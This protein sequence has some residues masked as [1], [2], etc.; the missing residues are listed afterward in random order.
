MNRDGVGGLDTAEGEQRTD[1]E[2]LLSVRWRSTSESPVAPFARFVSS[3]SSYIVGAVGDAAAVDDATSKA[4]LLVLFFHRETGET[5]ISLRLL[6]LLRLLLVW[7]GDGAY[8]K[9]V[10]TPANLSSGSDIPCPT[11]LRRLP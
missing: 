3:V 11:Y 6:F 9:G 4:I 8:G 7:T 2:G 10:L 1:R 5:G